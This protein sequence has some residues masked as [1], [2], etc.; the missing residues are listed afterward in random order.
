MAPLSLRT[1]TCFPEVKA[2]VI[3]QGFGGFAVRETV[4]GENEH[5]HWLLETEKKI[6]A[7]RT[8]LNRAIPDLKGNGKY[9]L[10]EVKELDKYE[11]Y[12]CKGESEGTGCEVAW[13]NSLLYDETKVEA[14]HAAYWE[15]NKKMKKRT[16]G[17]MIDFVVDAA[18][19][20]EVQYGQREKLSKIYIRE[21]GKR[22]KPINL[23]SIRSNLN[24]IQLAL[25]PD[26][27]ILDQL[28]DC[29]T[30]Y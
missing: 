30:Q 1:D 8:S 15:A 22:G 24:S 21:L 2:W 4:V 13:R 20:A 12:L 18:K 29:V 7:V 5:W 9:S 19:E 26:D 14:L 25:C 3:A 28:A 23:F 11:K 17:S 6:Q 27:T 16:H 10:T